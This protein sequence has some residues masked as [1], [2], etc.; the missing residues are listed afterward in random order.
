MIEQ[1]V[2]LSARRAYEFGPDDLRLTVLSVSEVSQQIQQF[3]SFQVVQIGTPL[4][5]FGPIPNTMPPGLAFDYGTT[6]TPDNVPT[7]MRFLHVEPQRIV[8]DVAGPSSAIDWTFE[9]LRF[10]LTEARA[11]DGAPAIGEPV[12]V[13]EYSEISIRYGFGFEEMIGGPLL[14]LAG[15]AFGET[16]TPLGIKFKAVDPEVGV[17]PAEVGS[18]S[19]S[20]G[21]L[22]ELRAGTRPDDNTFFSAAELPTDRHLSWL[23]ALDQGVDEARARTGR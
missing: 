21:N 17:R 10:I 11:P 20:Q 7:P 16:T 4:Q 9:Q 22:I 19:F 6:Q 5:T 1:T 15:G 2:I 13:R 18:M 12:S 8:V 23:Q 14:D 3:F